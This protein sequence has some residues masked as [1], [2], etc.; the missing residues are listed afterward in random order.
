M[1]DRARKGIKEVGF[2]SFMFSLRKDG[3]SDRQR[4]FRLSSELLLS[5]LPNEIGLCSFD[6]S[7]RCPSDEMFVFIAEV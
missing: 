2:P 6:D 1:L 4:S 7:N 3:Y 5:I